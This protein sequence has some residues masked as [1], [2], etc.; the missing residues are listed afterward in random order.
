MPISYHGGFT[1][2]YHTGEEMP[3]DER[4]SEILSNLIDMN[5]NKIYPQNFV[6]AQF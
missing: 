6:Y 1:L 3:L 5:N 4:S 2:I